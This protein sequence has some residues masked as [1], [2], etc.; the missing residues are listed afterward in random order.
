[1]NVIVASAR[2]RTPM[3]SA[4]KGNATGPMK[5]TPMRRRSSISSGVSAKGTKF[6]TGVRRRSSTVLK[7]QLSYAQRNQVQALPT[8][9]TAATREAAYYAQVCKD[10]LGD[11]ACLDIHS[12][13]SIDDA[14][15]RIMLPVPFNSL[16]R[17]CDLQRNVGHSLSNVGPLTFICASL[18]FQA[19]GKA[20]DK[21]SRGLDPITGRPYVAKVQ[22]MCFIILGSYFASENFRFCLWYSTYISVQECA[23]FFSS[24]LLPS[25]TLVA[26]PKLYSSNVGAF[27]VS[28]QVLPV[29]PQSL[30][31]LVR[32][33]LSHEHCAA[34][35]AAKPVGGTGS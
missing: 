2:A 20:L 33:A 22:G 32:L 30:R 27:Q 5:S 28:R 18:Q 29:A 31:V 16:P 23:L 24:Q 7:G 10:C 1:M 9:A 17:S 35:F 3:P 12:M 13:G 34:A 6:K 19:R 14:K 21:N 15:T 26:H 11:A 8:I 25:I 4:V